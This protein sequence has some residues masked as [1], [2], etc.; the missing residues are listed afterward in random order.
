MRRR[1]RYLQGDPLPLSR[2]SESLS[3]YKFQNSGQSK[4]E[5]EERRIIIIIITTFGEKT[6]NQTKN[7]RKMG[8]FNRLEPR[9]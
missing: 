3:E 4:G 9:G 7:G 6:K 1:H 5:E 8:T 2:A